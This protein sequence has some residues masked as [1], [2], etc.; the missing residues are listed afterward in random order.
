MQTK[1]QST[2]EFVVVMWPVGRPIPYARNARNISQAAI[3]KCAAS[4]KEFGWRQPIVVDE[5]DVIVA[6]HTRLAAAQK[7]GLTEVPVHVAVG[8]TK[9]RSKSTG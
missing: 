1:T 9:G 2:T 6:G 5:E 3:D 4:I 7:L 8:L